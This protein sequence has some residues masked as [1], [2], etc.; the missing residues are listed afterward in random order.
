MFKRTFK[1]VYRPI[2]SNFVLLPDQYY[3]VVSTYDTGCL[4]LQYNGRT[5]YASWAPQKGG[6][7]IKDTEI[8]I[9]ARAAKEIGLHENDLVKCALIADVLN[10]RSVHVTPVSSKDWEIIELST[11]KISGSVLEQT[12]IVNSTQILIV[13]INKSMQVALTVDRLKPHMNYGRIDH[14]TELVV[15]PNLYKGLTNGT[16]NG[17]IEENAKLSRSKTTAQVNDELTEKPTPL[18]HSSTVSNVKNTIQRNKRQDRMERLKKDLRRE[19]SR[20]F[21]FR[22]IR[23]LWREQAQESDVFVN[24][25]HLPE[26]FDLDLFYCMHTAGDKDYYV[27][28]RTVEDDIQDDLPETIHPSI[29]LNANLMKLLGIKELERVVLKPKTT[30][31]NFV[32]KIELFANKKTHYKIMEN[33]FKRFVIE[34]TQHKPMLF[35]QEE[36]VRLE[37]DLLVTVGILPEHFRYCVVDAQFLKESKIYAA[38]LV[39]P[40]GD[41]IKEETPPTS[42]L[43]VQD[44]IQLPEYDKIVDQVVQE[45]RMNLCLSADNSVMRQCNVL[46]AGAS[47]TGKT[48]LVERILD[49]LSRKPDYCYFEFFHGSRSKGRKTES[50]QKDLRNIFTSCLQHAPAIVVLENLDVLA[51]AA[52]EQSSQDGEY[53]NRMADTVYQL[54]V[55]YT[56]NNAIA[57]IAT[58]NELQTLNKRLSSPRGRH[59]FQTVARLPS[60]ER[61]DREIILREL[62]SH[63]NVAKDL[64]LVKFSNLTEGYRKC[65]LVQF[66]ER[67]IFYAYR[68]SKTQP[69]LTND[70]LI[71][72]LEHTNSYCLQGIQSNQKT[73]SDA[74]AN[75]MRVEELPG[76]ESVV[77][78]L[79]EVLMWPSR[80]P[81]IFNASPL[82]NQAGVLLYGPP[83][84]GKTYLVSQLATSWNLRIISVKGPELLAK[85]I[86]QSEENVRNLFNRARSARPCVLFFDEFDSL[87][88]K[89]GHDSTGVTDRVVNQLL[90]ELDG[91]EGLQGVTVIAATS[92]PELLD[93]ALLRSGRIDRLVECPL[94]DAP[95]RVRI[96]EALSSTLSLDECVD[97]DWFAGK[98]PNYT[99]AD[100]QSILTSANMAAVKEALAQFGHEKLPKKISLKQKHL[101]E[102]FQTTRPSLSASDVAK[103]HKTY[104]RFTNKEKTSREFVAKRAT[105]A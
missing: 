105:L 25:K 98:T 54:I 59:V 63:I 31:V 19:S 81:T 91:V 95:A 76:L 32:E 93:P 10:L 79:E 89:R 99:G 92:R 16:S 1:V 12:R 42:P 11:E 56:T 46:L 22:V 20:S 48:V 101:I 30:V 104:A 55:Q 50:I 102:S 28:V 64:D 86:G 8:G 52:G 39:R 34:R 4:S 17:V 44:L 100:I 67:A 29:E 24:G 21:E 3:G 27:R 35:N 90:T 36:V 15:A 83:G 38:D 87:A 68:I 78:V 61:A 37:D 84:T 97:F 60:L 41:I 70:Q 13:W 26:F 80:Y 7:G 88:P 23:G 69:L 96:F 73:G 77:G 85:Y 72:S 53:Y 94:P 40:V 75:E 43:S 62:C 103:Y 51:H 74:E 57:V 5:H 49:Q 6:G 45:L 66:V 33:A 65:D 2:R 14:N 71:E 47:G 9:N 58:V 82:R 18:T